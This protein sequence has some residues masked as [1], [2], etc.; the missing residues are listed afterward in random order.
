[1]ERYA[2]L[3]EFSWTLPIMWLNILFLFLILKKFFWDKIRN[4]MLA[5]EASV[6]DA[7]ENADNV[8][9][10]ADEKLA[11]Y[12]KQIAN[13]ESEGREIIRA[14]KVKAD[15]QAKSIVDEA[16][17]K[18]SNMIVQAQSEIE[19]EKQ[20]AVAEMK[21]QIADLAILAAE[22]ILQKEL[23]AAGQEA[24]IMDIIEEAGR[25]QWQN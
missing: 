11:D 23:D 9:R 21:G 17:E 3:I 6:R 24:M 16:S 10:L 14:A 7:F 2:E 12:E 18:A 5:R 25:S 20:K 1:M 8:N 15:A 22:R 19:R 4:F 13:I